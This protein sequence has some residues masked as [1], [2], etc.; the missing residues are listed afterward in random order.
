MALS[1]SGQA[2]VVLGVCATVAISVVS[3]GRAYVRS[4]EAQRKGAR[5]DLSP[6]VQDRMSRIEQAVDAIAIE[7]ER[8]S[9]G[10]RFT[11]RLLAERLGED[12]RGPGGPAHAIPRRSTGDGTNSAGGTNER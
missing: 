5:P 2:I 1:D 11:T 4:I 6:E 9:E 3:I 12:G 8:M 10:Q 7:V